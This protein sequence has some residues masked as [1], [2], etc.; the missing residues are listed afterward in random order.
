M[1][2]GCGHRSEISKKICAS[3]DNVKNVKRQPTE[4]ENFFADRISGKGHVSRIYKELNIK[5]QSSRK[6][7]QEI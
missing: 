7:G 3:K 6:N 2:H 5:R 4:L 1:C